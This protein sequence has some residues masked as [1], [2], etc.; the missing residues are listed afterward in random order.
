V[1]LH[2]HN[3][4]WAALEQIASL[5]P[6][7]ALPK[8][9]RKVWMDSETIWA[10]RRRISELIQLIRPD[11]RRMLM[12]APE[13]KHLESLPKRF[14]VY[15]GAKHWN[16]RGMSWTLDLQRAV[17]FAAHHFDGTECSLPPD[18]IGVV[19]ERTIQKSEVLFYND[20]RR[21]NEVVLKRFVKGPLSPEGMLWAAQYR[22][23]EAFAAEFEKQKGLLRPEAVDTAQRFLYV[24][25]RRS[26]T[27]DGS[28]AN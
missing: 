3:S 22:G 18:M 16:L 5:V 28:P 10:E 11:S 13:R 25:A 19:M 2:E 26:N 15:R 1:L 14:T 23:N 21:E 12:T 4:R 8:V 9:F 20:T 17:L 6:A 24:M 7:D 27:S